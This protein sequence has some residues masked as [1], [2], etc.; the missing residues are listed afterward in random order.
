MINYPYYAY[1]D[2]PKIRK[3]AIKQ[4]RLLKNLGIYWNKL[5][6]E[7]F[8]EAVKKAANFKI[9]TSWFD[10]DIKPRLFPD[11]TFLKQCS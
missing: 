1:V 4:E 11:N 2:S 3:G 9:L 5:A 6:N 8:K 7:G 10:N